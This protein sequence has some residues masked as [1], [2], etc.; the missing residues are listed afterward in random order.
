ML[1]SSPGF[2]RNL[3]PIRKI[4]YRGEKKSNS[5]QIETICFVNVWPVIT[6][7]SRVNT[8]LLWSS[9]LCLAGSCPEGEKHFHLDVT[10]VLIP[11]SRSP[12]GPP[13]ARVH[14]ERAT[15]FWEPRG[16]ELQGSNAGHN[17]VYR[18]AIGQRGQNR[19]EIYLFLKL[20]FD[21][22]LNFFKYN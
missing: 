3:F 4:I 17:D 12:L 9:L 20:P 11:I 5:P 8:S 6:V 15:T 19:V 21:I 2:A 14:G 1:L 7:A 10:L 22:T 13:S 18:A 16:C